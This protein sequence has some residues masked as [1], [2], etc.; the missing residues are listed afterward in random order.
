[1]KMIDFK[2]LHKTIQFQ[3]FSIY[4][5]QY[6]TYMKYSIGLTRAMYHGKEI[7]FVLFVLNLVVCVGES[8]MCLKSFAIEV[9]FSCIAPCFSLFRKS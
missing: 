1:M 9:F 2:M 3:E 5:Q 4:W 6:V 8:N 7:S